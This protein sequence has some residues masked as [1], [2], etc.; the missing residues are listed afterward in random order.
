MKRFMIVSTISIFCLALIGLLV[1]NVWIRGDVKSNIAFVQEKYGGTPEAALIAFLK[2]ET[3]SK[4]ERT[5][6]AVWTLGQLESQK[7]LPHLRELYK[8]DP[9][10]KTCKDKHDYLICQY[11]LYKAINAVEKGKL[12][13]YSKL[14]P[15]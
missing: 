15:Q 13:S 3:N 11:E 12:L 1:L 9:K 10:G 6:I 4:S 14:K 5:H 8:G 2:D 7:A